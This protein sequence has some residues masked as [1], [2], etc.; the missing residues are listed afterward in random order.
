M[1][2]NWHSKSIRTVLKEIGSDEKGLSFQEAGIRLEKFGHNIFDQ[3][4]PDSLLTIFLSQFKSP[5]I[6]ILGSRLA[7]YL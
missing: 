7:D 4:K 6:Y 5:L 3:V 1:E 2:Y